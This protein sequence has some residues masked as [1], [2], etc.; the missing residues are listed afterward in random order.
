MSKDSGSVVGGLILVGAV[1]VVASLIEGTAKR[2]SKKA[3]KN[4]MAELS[5][6]NQKSNQKES[7]Y[8]S[9]RNPEYAYCEKCGKNTKQCLSEWHHG[10]NR[11][12]DCHGG[13]YYTNQCYDCDDG[14]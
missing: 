10:D 12:M 5:C 8:I 7:V 9:C 2:Q 6:D 1:L 4:E 3:E 14:G 13:E 11:C